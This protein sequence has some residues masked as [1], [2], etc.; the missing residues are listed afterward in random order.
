MVAHTAKHLYEKCIT[1]PL[2]RGRTRILVTHHVKL[3]LPGAAYLV[4][5]AG[6]RAN[7][8]G[9]PAEL[10]SRGVLADIL[11][12]RKEAEE[13]LQDEVEENAADGPETTT[14]LTADNNIQVRKAPKVLVEEESKY[15]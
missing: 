7:H 11:S 6:G 12:E 10:R 5:I 8:V 1:G 2:M 14:T 3:C 15:P 13:A 9:S 4:H